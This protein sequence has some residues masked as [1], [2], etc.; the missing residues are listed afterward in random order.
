MRTEESAAARQ[1]QNQML[2][3]LDGVQTQLRHIQDR[4]GDQRNIQTSL[5]DLRNTMQ[6]TMKQTTAQLSQMTQSGGVGTVFLAIVCAI[7]VL[8]AMVGW[9]WKRAHDARNRKLF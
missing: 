4:L 1:P 6:M 3:R 9:V 2:Q 5:D 8:V 7:A